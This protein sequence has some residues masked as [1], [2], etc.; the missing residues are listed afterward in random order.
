[1]TGITAIMITVPPEVPAALAV[2]DRDQALAAPVAEDRVPVPARPAAAAADG[3]TAAEDPPVSAAFPVMAAVASE[4]IAA[5]SAA[6]MAVALE[7]T[8]VAAEPA[9]TN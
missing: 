3:L 5:A 7:V 8:A 2:P 4:V 1:M 6:V 9:G